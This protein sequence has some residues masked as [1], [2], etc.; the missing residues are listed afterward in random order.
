MRLHSFS[1]RYA[2]AHPPRRVFV[3]VPASSVKTA[4][5]RLRRDDPVWEDKSV[6][7]HWSFDVPKHHRCRPT[8]RL[9]FK[10]IPARVMH[11]SAA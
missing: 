7:Y 4:L 6:E 5:K 10:V 3:I 11:A 8:N 9:R 2:R 1:V